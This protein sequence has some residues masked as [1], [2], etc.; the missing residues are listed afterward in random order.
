MAEAEFSMK[1]IGVVET[2]YPEKFGIPR[3]PGL[4]KSARGKV[5]FDEAFKN[6]D[7]IRGLEGFSHIWLVFVFHE[8]GE[9]PGRAMVRPPRLGGNERRGVFATRAPYRPNSI[10]LS[11]VELESIGEDGSL[12]LKGVDLV[13]GTPLLDVKPY[14]PFCDAVP[15]ARGGFVSGV[16][17]TME[18]IWGC[19]QPEDPEALEVIEESLAYD[20]RPAYKRDEEEREYG[21]AIA[22]YELRWQV[23]AGIATV[24]KCHPQQK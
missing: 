19:E 4:V 13:D 7:M 6:P 8:A 10:G 23:R 21:C 22:G 3:Q 24:L 14:I 20:P 9:K 18:V 1:R 11:V 5:V 15:D 12:Y 2:C 16:P 17:E